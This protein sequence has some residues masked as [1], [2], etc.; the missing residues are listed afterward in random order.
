MTKAKRYFVMADQYYSSA[1]VLLE[2]MISTG[3]CTYG[4]GN[5]EKMQK[6]KC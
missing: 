6:K 2:E 3:N 4:F 5:T 1:K